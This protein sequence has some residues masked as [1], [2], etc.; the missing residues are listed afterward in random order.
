MSGN[1]NVH[2]YL[3]TVNAPWG[4]LFYKLVWH[5]IDCEGKRI[6]DFGSGFGI[7][8]DYFAKNNDVTAIEPN[9]EMIK[10]RFCNNEYSQIVGGI[11]ELRKLPSKS[12]DVIICH[13]VFEYLDNRAELLCEFSRVLK[14]DG[15]ASIVKHNKAGKIMQKAVF[16]YKI[17]EALELINNGNAVSEN[18]GT[19]NEYDNYELEKYC[20]G[21]F[22]IYKIYGVRMFFG[23]QRNELK[24]ESDWISSM[25][26][27]ECTTEE[28]P[29]FRNIAFFHHVILKR[30]T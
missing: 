1:I 11:D 10:H 12:Y 6:L 4:K 20:E 14:L 15:F 29:E 21:S 22:K 8:A 18:F 25:Y 5:N 7:T 13:N 17:N 2:G 9:E 19:I 24:N 23:L 26:N 3:D 16:E 30:T 28:I 27:L